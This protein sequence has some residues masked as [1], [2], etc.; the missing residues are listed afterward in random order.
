MTE[1]GGCSPRHL[2]GGPLRGL[3]GDPRNLGERLEASEGL[4][5]LALPAHRAVTRVLPRGPVKDVLHGVW[6]GH[7][8]HP[9]LT[10]LPI[11]FW[12]SAFV[13]DL[14]GGRRAQ[15][16]A[17]ALVGLGVAA[18][19]PTAAAGLADWSELNTPERRS[20]A[21]HAVTNLAATALYALSFRARRRGKRGRGVA[22]AM[23]GATAA[24]AGGFLGG[25]LTFRRS[26]GVNQTANV[27]TDTSWGELEL[28]GVI[29]DEPV[30]AHLGDTSLATV[31]VD[32]EAMGLF[33]RCS[34]LGGPLHEGELIDGCLRC[35]WHGSTFRIVDGAVVR[36]PAT[37]PQP[38]YEL[39]GD[40]DTRQ[41]RR[42][43]QP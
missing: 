34:H 24:T 38:A 9:P 7:P 10:D 35:P 32:G 20:G 4:D 23:A 43:M 17:D 22:L 14:L 11:G 1:T 3:L 26:A 6:L 40:G 13:L 12:S 19:V 21:V 16:A 28:G 36:G 25:H 8:L 39:R 15:P 5:Q 30:L 31:E 29:G 41:A 37:A 42:R 18:A 27:P 33:D 2:I